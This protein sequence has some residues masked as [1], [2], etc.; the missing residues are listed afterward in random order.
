MS[1]FL[2][3]TFA[4][5]FFARALCFIFIFSIFIFFT[6]CNS[7]LSLFPIFFAR[8]PLC[9]SKQIKIEASCRSERGSSDSASISSRT[10]MWELPYRYRS[11]AVGGHCYIYTTTRDASWQSHI[12]SYNVCITSRWPDEVFF[13]LLAIFIF[14]IQH[15]SMRGNLAHANYNGR[16]AMCNF[17]STSGSR[18]NTQT[19]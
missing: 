16:L 4:D 19:S 7:F 15:S 9:T 11:S 10:R 2:A 6:F 3:R 12:K 5:T 14:S 1:G 17:G 8:P 18:L 13:F